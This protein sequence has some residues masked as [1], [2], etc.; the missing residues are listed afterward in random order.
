VVLQQARSLGLPM[1]GS[2]VTLFGARVEVR[3]L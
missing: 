2:A 1:L 3:S